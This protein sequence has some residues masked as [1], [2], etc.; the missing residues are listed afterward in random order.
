MDKFRKRIKSYNPRLTSYQY[1]LIQNKAKKYPVDKKS[2][3]KQAPNLP[4][5]LPHNLEDLLPLYPGSIAIVCNGPIKYTIGKFIDSHDVV[6]RFN[7]YQIKGFEQYVGQ[8]TTFWCTVAVHY[9]PKKEKIITICPFTSKCR[10]S[11]YTHRVPSI[12]LAKKRAD[13]SLLKPTTGY[14]LIKLIT[15]LG[16]QVSVFGLQGLEGGHYWNKKDMPCSFHDGPK[17]LNILRDDP[18]AIIYT[19]DINESHKYDFC[20]SNYKSYRK[21]NNGFNT[22]KIWAQS[23]KTSNILEFGAGNG[24]FSNFLRDLGHRVTAIDVSAKACQISPTK[25]IRGGPTFLASLTNHF[26]WGVCF[27]VLEHLSLNDIDIVLTQFRRLCSKIRLTIST[28]PSYL[29]GPDHTNLHKTIND[30]N[31]WYKKLHQFFKTIKIQVKEDF[32]LCECKP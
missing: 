7:N 10:E 29:L 22:S 21:K 2:I 25:I 6:I 28:R 19:D 11:E 13:V 24:L 32:L 20:F 15:N 26:D 4:I 16:R 1:R 5:L 9:I 14:M 12:I 8:K 27:D 3:S 17:E 23:I 30:K 18:L 31:W